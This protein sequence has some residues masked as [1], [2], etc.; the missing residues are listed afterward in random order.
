MLALLGIVHC[1]VYAWSVNYVPFNYQSALERLYM[2]VLDRIVLVQE[3]PSRPTPAAASRLSAMAD[4]T[5]ARYE[6]NCV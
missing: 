5:K 2:Y 6:L 3:K 4:Q 1:G